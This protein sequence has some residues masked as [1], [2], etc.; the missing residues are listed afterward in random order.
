MET[1][2]TLI[3]HHNHSGEE[4]QLTQRKNPELLEY[5]G[6]KTAVSYVLNNK[7]TRLNLHML[8]VVLRFPATL[9]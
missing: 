9:C 5:K 8:H 4:A 7:H 1:E 2:Q 6:A 3:P